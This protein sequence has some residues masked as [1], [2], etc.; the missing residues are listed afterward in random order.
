LFRKLN[1]HLVAG[2]N[3]FYVNKNN[4]YTEGFIGIENIFKI[5]RLD[6]VWGFEQGKQSAR[7]FRIGLPLFNNRNTD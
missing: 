6:L 5:L 3:A 1:W 2:S 4:N 7:G